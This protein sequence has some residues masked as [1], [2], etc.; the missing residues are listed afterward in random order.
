MDSARRRK[1]V[2]NRQ[3]KIEVVKQDLAYKQGALDKK[4]LSRVNFKAFILK[5]KFVF[6]GLLVF[7]IVAGVVLVVLNKKSDNIFYTE[8]IK[9]TIEESESD[10]D[11]VNEQIIDDSLKKKR[12]SFHIFIDT[13]DFHIDNDII[14]GG[15]DKDLNNGI[16]HQSGSAFPSK[17]GGNVVITGHRWYPGDGEFS[18]I[19]LDL[20]KLKKGDEVILT[21]GDK[22]YKYIVESSVIV[23]ENENDLLGSTRESYLTLYTCH[24]KYTS[25]KRLVYRAKLT[26]IEDKS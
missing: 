19:F 22:K 6:V 2:N 9:K 7:G 12:E 10:A 20:D 3:R 21:Y 17:Y 26:S 11:M 23:P 24:P 5:Y 18:K 15:S 16:I 25:D 13:K 8:E 1:C 14:E 4:L